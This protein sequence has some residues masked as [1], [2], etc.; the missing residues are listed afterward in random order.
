[1]CC[2]TA[3]QHLCV[4]GKQRKSETLKCSGDR[5]QSVFIT[6]QVLL[7]EPVGSVPVESSDHVFLVSAFYRVTN[8]KER[9]KKFSFVK[10]VI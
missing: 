9:K 6:W 10:E 2:R 5:Q 1:M 7:Q 8:G 4:K 3:G